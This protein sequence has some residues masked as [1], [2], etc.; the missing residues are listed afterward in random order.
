MVGRLDVESYHY[1]AIVP[2]V[3]AGRAGRSEDSRDWLQEGGFMTLRI[4]LVGLVASMGFELP[5]TGDFSSWTQSGREWVS[6]RMADLTGPVVEADGLGSGPTGCLQ[7]ESLDS[8]KSSVVA[9][10][11][12]TSEDAAFAAISEAMATEFAADAVLTAKTPLAVESEPTTLAVEAPP[13]GLPDGE[14]LAAQVAT[15]SVVETAETEDVS[16]S[17]RVSSALRETCEAVRAWV[18]LIQ[19]STDEPSL[20]Y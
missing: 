14:E 13:V 4:M 2:G 15:A 3:L 20:D 9:E 12:K 6:A 7:A 10:P 8:I 16:R 18:N 1:R 5:G 17:D 11:V 19:E